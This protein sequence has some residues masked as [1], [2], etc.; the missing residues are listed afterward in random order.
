M[1]RPAQSER[2]H[3]SLR[4]ENHEV[5]LYI[6]DGQ[7]MQGWERD[8]M[9]ASADLLCEHGSE[10]LEIG[11]GLGISALRIAGHPGTR[12][13]VV[14]EKY[15]EVIDLFRERTPAPPAALEVIQAD[16][17]D[18]VGALPVNAFDGI[19]FDPY[20]PAA[21]RNDQAL[22]DEVMP[23]LARVLRAGGV[24]LPCFTTRPTLYWIDYFDRVVVRRRAYTAYETTTYVARV[25]GSAYIHC[26]Y[27]D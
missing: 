13:H 4:E 16:F 3:V 17:F 19:F 12:R 1:K 2:P 27:R 25:S 21:I 9:H 18:Y 15:R 26:Y 24:F 5:T 10:F 11:L 14:L 6:D 22:W 8:L 20:L 23:R 7:A